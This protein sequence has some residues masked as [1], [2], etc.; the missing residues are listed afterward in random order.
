[1]CVFICRKDSK[2]NWNGLS[3]LMINVLKSNENLMK[4]VFPQTGKLE[5]LTKGLLLSYCCL[6]HQVL[7]FFFLF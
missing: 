6:T 3:I 1:M 5:N 4:I 7:F 2:T